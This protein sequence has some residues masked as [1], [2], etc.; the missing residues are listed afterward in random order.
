MIELTSITTIPETNSLHL[1]IGAPWK[2]RF[3]LET[4]IFMGYVSLRED[5]TSWA[6]CS[7]FARFGH[8]PT[9][10]AF[11]GFVARSLTLGML[12]GWKQPICLIKKW[13]KADHATPKFQKQKRNLK[14]T[15]CSF[16]RTQIARGFAEDDLFWNEALLGIPRLCETL[17]SRNYGFN[18]GTQQTGAPRMKRHRNGKYM[19]ILIW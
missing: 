11:A 18:N 12:L 7:R 9:T 10:K 1:K 15:P 19:K 2:R 14:R 3:L 8:L 16:R 5:T 4:T 6:H 17:T 13:S